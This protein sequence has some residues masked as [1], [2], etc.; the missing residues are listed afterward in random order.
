MSRFAAGGRRDLRQTLRVP[1]SLAAVS[2]MGLVAGLFGDGLWD[3]VSWA[4]VGLPIAAVVWHLVR[5]G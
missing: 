5:S 2:L 3:V 4:A 1:A